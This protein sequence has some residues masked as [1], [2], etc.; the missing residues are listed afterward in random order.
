MILCLQLKELECSYQSYRAV[1]LHWRIELLNKRGLGTGYAP[2]I[3]T[4]YHSFILRF[5]ESV[6]P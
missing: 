2:S 1:L 4:P 6:V 3:S 5:S